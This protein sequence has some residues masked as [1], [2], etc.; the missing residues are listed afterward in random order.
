MKVKSVDT[1]FAMVLLSAA[2]KS[3]H[4][5]T[6]ELAAQLAN[7]A[8]CEKCRFV[9][10]ACRCPSTPTEPTL[11]KRRVVAA[12]IRAPD[13]TLL[14]GIRHYSQDMVDQI[15]KRVD[16]NKFK[17][18]HDE[19]QGFVDQH[20]KWLSRHEAYAVALAANQIVRPSAC[21]Q[22]LDGMKLYSEG[23]Y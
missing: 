12:A 22:D 1:A 19:D 7:V 13:G 15:E 21:G 16:G 3:G 4:A 17:H 5:G 8:P 14:V 10:Y 18:R 2:A 11:D 20:G 9:W 6:L 23:L